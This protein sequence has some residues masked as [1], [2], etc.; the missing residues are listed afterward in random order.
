MTL[1]VGIRKLIKSYIE[2]GFDAPK[3]YKVL[4]KTVS[5]ATVYRWVARI[6]KNRIS[7]K[8]SPGRPRTVRTKSF[9]AKI[10]R[11][12]CQNKKIK[13]ARKIS[14]DE[15]AHRRPCCLQSEKT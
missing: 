3:I 10:K 5:R 7:S 15:D 6:T 8:T 4:N 12:L 13:S 14:R 1:N 2:S 11:N 9:I